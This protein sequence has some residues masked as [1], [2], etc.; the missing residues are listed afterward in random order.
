MYQLCNTVYEGD[1]LIDL[2][3]F[4]RF[5]NE[6]NLVD[7]KLTFRKEGQDDYTF[8]V[9]KNENAIII[10]NKDVDISVPAIT[11]NLL[12][13]IGTKDPVLSHVGV[14]EVFKAL[15]REVKSVSHD[16]LGDSVSDHA[17]VFRFYAHTYLGYESCEMHRIPFAVMKSVFQSTMLKMRYTMYSMLH[18][19]FPEEF[20]SCLSK[21]EKSRLNDYI[22]RMSEI[23]ALI[24]KH[25]LSSPTALSNEMVIGSNIALFEWYYQNDQGLSDMVEEFRNF[26]AKLKAEI[27][28]SKPDSYELENKLMQ[29]DLQLSP[30]ELKSKLHYLAMLKQDAR[31]RG[32]ENDFEILDCRTEPLT[33]GAIAEVAICHCLGAVQQFHT[34][35]CGRPLPYIRMDAEMDRQGI[36]LAIDDIPIQLKFSPTLSYHGVLDENTILLSP[37]KSGVDM[38]QE[39]LVKCNYKYANTSITHG[40]DKAI[41]DLWKDYMIE[42]NIVTK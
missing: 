4:S 5:V 40:F 12:T 38:V 22:Y 10:I 24:K 8:R 33:C 36:D 19:I 7:T 9:I 31:R 16:I 42:A 23:H 29:S 3:K 27:T 21:S 39:L 18:L 2:H 11:A 20:E 1:K 32:Y 26:K 13:C 37:L 14:E 34:K 17:I 35:Y 15:S 30:A 41:N 6:S 25:D 28:N